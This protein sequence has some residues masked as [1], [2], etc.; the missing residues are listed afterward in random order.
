MPRILDRVRES[1]GNNIVAILASSI[2]SFGPTRRWWAANQVVHHHP[3]VTDSR[4]RD[5]R[6]VCQALHAADTDATE[7]IV[8]QQVVRATE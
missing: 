3:E 4:I 5:H 7:N 2:T 8:R 6:E 1:S